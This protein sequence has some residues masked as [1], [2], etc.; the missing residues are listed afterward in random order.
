MK[1]DADGS[2]QRIAVLPIPA[3]TYGQLTSVG[4]K[5]YYLRKGKLFLFELDKEKETELGDF[6]G[7][8]VSAD[9]KKML[10]VGGGDFAIIDLPTGKIDTKDKTLSLAEL[11]VKLDRRAEWN[12]IYAECWR[13]MRDFVYDPQPARR[14]LAGDARSATSRCWPTSST[15]PISPTSSAR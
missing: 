4:D 5:L 10:V 15:G 9:Q 8:R 6:G 7:Y 3:S 12:Q 13:Q 14:G 2:P 1:V 11:K